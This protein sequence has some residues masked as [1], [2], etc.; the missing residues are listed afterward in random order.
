MLFRSN[1]LDTCAA[2]TSASAS[3][4]RLMGSFFSVRTGGPV[5]GDATGDIIANIYLRRAS[6]STDPAGTLRIVG[7]Y[8]QCADSACA[9]VTNGHSMDLGTAV[10]GQKVQLQLEWDKANQQFAYIVDGGTPVNHSYVGMLGARTGTP[11][12]PF[13]HVAVRN[14]VPNCVASRPM[15]G[16]EALFDNFGLVH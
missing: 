15:A 6:N 7:A 1:H 14:E 12:N 2:N 5:A 10:V 11:G 4:A 3:R 16:M 8:A 9:T 13:N